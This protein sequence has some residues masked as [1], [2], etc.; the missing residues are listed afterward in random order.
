MESISKKI[1]RI[2][3]NQKK[4]LL[5]LAGGVGLAIAGT[6][7]AYFGVIKGV[8]DE[9][10]KIN[11]QTLKNAIKS[12]YQSRL[13]EERENENGSTSL[14]LS[15]GGR[16]KILTYNIDNISINKP[17]KW[18]GKWRIVLFDI[19]NFKRKERDILR[20]ILKRIGFAKYQ[21][22][23][24]VI[25]YECKKEFDYIVELYQLRPY[26]R[27]IEAISFDDDLKFKNDFGLIS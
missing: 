5:L 19:P 8:S 20:S 3:P 17:K 25:P 21:E 12:L 27:I 4:V 13:I 18:D 1:D 6:P 7:K 2:G 10:A 22:S 15:E 11:E 26:V 14:V 23:V 24:F 16:K 9:W